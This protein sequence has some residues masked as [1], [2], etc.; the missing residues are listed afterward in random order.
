MQQKKTR[1]CPWV[2]YASKVK[3]SADFILK[4]FNDVHKYLRQTSNRFTS[5]KWLANTYVD[6][7]LT[8][9]KWLA[10]TYADQLK[11]K[12]EWMLVNS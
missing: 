10:S 9:V 3:D 4:A 11:V 12:K 1:S 5:A 6:Q 2:C 8:S 7:W